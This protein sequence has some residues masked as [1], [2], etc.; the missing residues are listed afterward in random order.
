MWQ[1]GHRRLT[2]VPVPNHFGNPGDIALTLS[3][4]VPPDPLDCVQTKPDWKG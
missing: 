2:Y 3:A 4:I 1:I